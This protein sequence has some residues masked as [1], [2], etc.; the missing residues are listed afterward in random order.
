MVSFLAS[1]FFSGF[2]IGFLFIGGLLSRLVRG[3]PQVGVLYER[4]IVIFHIGRGLEF[5]GFCLFWFR[6][7]ARIC[8]RVA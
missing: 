2:E 3:I 7:L 6:G 8:P 5:C 4:S 1:G